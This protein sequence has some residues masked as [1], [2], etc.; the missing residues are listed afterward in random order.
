MIKHY[1]G[2]RY[3][4]KFATPVEWAADTSYEALTIV[5]FNNASYT[6]KIQVP[7]TVGNPANN[8][9]YWALTGNYNAQ[10]EQ[11]R[12][13][14]E[15]YN[16]QVESYK[17][18]IEA[19]NADIKDIFVTPE[20]FGAKGDGTTD[21]SKAV[22]DAIN[23]G[24]TVIFTNKEY[25]LPTGITI[26]LTSQ[27]RF[28]NTVLYANT[29]IPIITITGV[30]SDT[31]IDRVEKRFVVTLSGKCT[32]RGE[33]N[34]TGIKF[35]SEY[36]QMMQTIEDVTFFNLNKGIDFSGPDIWGITLIRNKFTGC[37]YGI[38]YNLGNNS[39]EKLSCIDASTGNCEYILY[40][41]TNAGGY[42]IFENC[43]LDYCGCIIYDGNSPYSQGNYYI[44][45]SH[46]ENIGL[47]DGIHGDYTGYIRKTGGLGTRLTIN[48][49]RIVQ[50]MDNVVGKMN[51]SLSKI[52]YHNCY[53][54]SLSKSGNKP[55]S[56]STPVESYD[57][58]LQPSSSNYIIFPGFYHGNGNNYIPLFF[59]DSTFPNS[60]SI[61]KPDTITLTNGT[62]FSDLWN[63]H[64][65]RI[66]SNA[67]VSLD[68]MSVT[69][70][71]PYNA[72]K[73]DQLL[74]AS[75]TYGNGYIDAEISWVTSSG[76]VIKNIPSVLKEHAPALNALIAKTKSVPSVFDSRPVTVIPQWPLADKIIVTIH[77]YVV[78]TNTLADSY[79]EF[80]AIYF[81]SV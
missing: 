39:S 7:P 24:K 81:C 40:N 75:R 65:V 18:A 28:N 43:S 79:A 49:S 17:L 66:T 48:N 31:E 11:Y 71:L 44:N 36:G 67:S 45:N 52:V 9:Q 74:L 50:S 4:P 12:Q 21:D 63:G 14:T 72:F 69:Y 37:K 2:A 26:T 16:A 6:S 23:T 51:D 30:R 77:F 76:S 3:V 34:E 55:L 13:E 20:M 35:D 22:Q 8:P 1:V 33:G 78:S 41:A 54:Q 59:G 56:T 68:T 46:I 80:N 64:S 58:V 73:T 29:S 5:T 19:L 10:V 15:N 27:L 42:F 32:L 53:F 25:Y 47:A 57:S 61:T 62:V 70:E 38:Y 60:S